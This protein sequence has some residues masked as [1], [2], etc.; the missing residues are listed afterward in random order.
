MFHLWR[1]VV[2][3]M[4]IL[5]Q[6]VLVQMMWMWVWVVWVR[7]VGSRRCEQMGLLLSGCLGGLLDARELGGLL[8]DVRVAQFV[9]VIVAHL[10]AVI[11]YS[12]RVGC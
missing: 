4:V 5:V 2:L 1:F 10:Y 7:W 8:E 6:M 11:S 3:V 9:R 12:V